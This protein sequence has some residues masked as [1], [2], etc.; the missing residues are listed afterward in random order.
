M[1]KEIEML[2]K[3]EVKNLTKENVKFDVALRSHIEKIDSAIKTL[4]TELK[5]YKDIAKE[6]FGE[7]GGNDIFETKTVVSFLLNT[8]ELIELIGTET[9][10]KLKNKES[11]KTYVKW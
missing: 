4:E 11:K 3:E 9:Y 8:D 2:T 10:E 6:V 7:N 5:R 1:K